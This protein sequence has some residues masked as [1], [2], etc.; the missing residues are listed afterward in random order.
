MSCVITFIALWAISVLTNVSV[1]YYEYIGL[2]SGADKGKSI[3]LHCTGTIA[4]YFCDG[5]KRLDK[6]FRFK[7]L[8]NI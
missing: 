2:V 8:L 7:T 5:R 1:C 3:R 4:L 6:L